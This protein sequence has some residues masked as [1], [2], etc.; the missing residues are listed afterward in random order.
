M[1]REFKM[2]FLTRMSAK[3]ENGLHE[4]KIGNAGIKNKWTGLFKADQYEI[5]K[6]IKGGWHKD[7]I[8]GW[9]VKWI[10]NGELILLPKP[11]LTV[12]SGIQNILD[13]AFSIG[14]PP[15]AIQTIGVDNG[16]SNPVAGDTNSTAGSSS[17]RLVAFDSTATRSSQTV[18]ASGTFTNSNVTF[19]MKRLFL[20][21]A[22]AGTT[23]SAG[24][25]IAMT[26]VFTLDFIT[27]SP[28]SSFSQ[29][30]TSQ[31]VGVGS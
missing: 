26:N 10:R 9:N 16:T 3:I 5:E 23:D 1:N 18:S 30:F 11:N 21:K 14:G 19:I 29:T 17:R 24:D 25:L 27:G 4:L 12:N 28:F 13:R 8:K 31:L 6:A 2:P 22:A 20:S 7:A 15:T